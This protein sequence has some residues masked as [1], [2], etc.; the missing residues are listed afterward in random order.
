MNNIHRNLVA[1]EETIQKPSG[2]ILTGPLAITISRSRDVRH[3]P[4]CKN[5]MNEETNRSFSL[6][7]IISERKD[8]RPP[9]HSWQ[10][11]A[12]AAQ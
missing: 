4:Q 11:P 6:A 10:E 3:C 8:N 9:S 5:Q 12:H 1:W 7:V 2:N